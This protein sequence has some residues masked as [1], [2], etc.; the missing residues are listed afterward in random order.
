MIEG[1]Q[2]F[3]IA[4]SR[5]GANAHACIEAK[6]RTFASHTINNRSSRA[7]MLALGGR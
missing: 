3:L 1:N 6:A 7:T 4:H 2:S 5:A